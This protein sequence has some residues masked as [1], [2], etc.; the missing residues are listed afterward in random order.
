MKQNEDTKEE[1]TMKKNRAPTE[2]TIERLGKFIYELDIITQQLTKEK[3]QQARRELALM[4][5]K[6]IN[7]FVSENSLPDE[8]QKPLE[9]IKER[10]NP[11][12]IGVS[13]VSNHQKELARTTRKASTDEGKGWKT[14]DCEIRL[15]P[16]K[17][18]GKALEFPVAAQKLLD[19]ILTK[20]CTLKN[21]KLPKDPKVSDLTIEVSI[22]EYWQ[23]I[24]LNVFELADR[25]MSDEELKQIKAN[26]KQALKDLRATADILTSLS[27][28]AKEYRSTYGETLINF[29]QE[30]NVNRKAQSV[31]SW[32]LEVLFG[33]TA[34]KFFKSQPQT[35]VHTE[36]FRLKNTENIEWAV[37]K[38]LGD[39]WYNFENWPDPDPKQNA[40]RPL[41]KQKDRHNKI[42]LAKLAE[43]TPLPK[44]GE[45]HRKENQKIRDRLEKALYRMLPESDVVEGIT[46]Q[47]GIG[48]LSDFKIVKKD[49][50]DEEKEISLADAF[51]CKDKFD[52]SDSLKG[53]DWSELRNCY[54]FFELAHPEDKTQQLKDRSAMIAYQEAQ[55]KKAE[56]NKKRSETMKK[57]NKKD[58]K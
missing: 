24:G 49:S 53:M 18:K 33:A 40:K 36:G 17:F 14:E 34:A 9:E 48:F 46:D 10:L 52:Q 4:A 41:S 11:Y 37:Y 32:Y 23:L 21:K 22:S 51:G 29:F 50:N 7:E 3:S 45:C 20:Y 43:A 25:T 2:T 27:V 19:F 55:R 30:I 47:G 1:R 54:L 16:N 26:R 15:D 57:K 35:T 6:M 44:A 5:T 56:A 42:C 8:V 39:H 58:S 38:K 28:R 31:D 12:V 13:S